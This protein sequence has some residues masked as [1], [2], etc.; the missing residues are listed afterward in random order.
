MIPNMIRENEDIGIPVWK[1]PGFF[2][3]LIWKDTEDRFEAMLARAGKLDEDTAFILPDS[4]YDCYNS[5]DEDQDPIVQ[6]YTYKACCSRSGIDYFLISH[7]CLTDNLDIENCVCVPQNIFN[8]IEFVN[9]YLTP[10]SG[11]QISL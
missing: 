7:G 3:W 1:T 9:Y 10:L 5:L 8:V 2:C 6:V 11:R 4:I